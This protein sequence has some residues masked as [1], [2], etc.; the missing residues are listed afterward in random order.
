MG[1]TRDQEENEKGVDQVGPHAHDGKLIRE[2]HRS[3]VECGGDQGSHD[4]VVSQALKKL[5]PEPLGM[6]V[7]L[8]D[9]PCG[10]STKQ[11]GEDKGSQNLPLGSNNV[12]VGEENLAQTDGQNLRRGSR[13]AGGDDSGS[14]E[15]VEVT[16]DA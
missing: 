4:D 13:W 6:F 2:E 10:G 14:S 15:A 7:G 12:V 1:T 11:S 16:V 3:C 8:R 5:R 9:P